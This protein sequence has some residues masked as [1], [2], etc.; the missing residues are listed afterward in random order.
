MCPERNSNFVL[1]NLA[2]SIQFELQ[3]YNPPAK[4]RVAIGCPRVVF[5]GICSSRSEALVSQ[6]LIEDKH[7]EGLDTIE[8]L[9]IIYIKPNKSGRKRVRH[10]GKLPLTR[11]GYPSI[12]EFLRLLSKNCLGS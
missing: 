3:R 6:F 5:E 2:D 8:Q 4:E 11:T 12:T 1:I 10:D 9:V 7:V